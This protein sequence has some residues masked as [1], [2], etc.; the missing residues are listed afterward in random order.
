LTA[1]F[2]LPSL[3]LSLARQIGESCKHGKAISR[4]DEGKGSAY[5]HIGVGPQS[6]RRGRIGSEGHGGRARARCVETRRIERSL[7]HKLGTVSIYLRVQRRRLE[8]HVASLDGFGVL[9]AA[10]NRPAAVN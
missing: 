8:R 5:V 3:G 7:P 2:V 6:G 10:L 4:R 1:L 9:S